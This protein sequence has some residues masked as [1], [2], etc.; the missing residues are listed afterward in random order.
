MLD[1]CLRTTRAGAFLG[2]IAS[3]AVNVG[4]FSAWYCPRFTYLLSIAA[5]IVFAIATATAAKS[6]IRLRE[7][8]RNEGQ[9]RIISRSSQRLIRRWEQCFIVLTA[10]Y[11][12]ICLL[13]PNA[14][15]GTFAF[16]EVL[17]PDSSRMSVDLVRRSGASL[18]MFS[19][20]LHCCGA[21]KK[22]RHVGTDLL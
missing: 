5:L 9:D 20:S 13:M 21:E 16:E 18:A 15:L 11:A 4:T 10:A 1:L 6:R 2:A 8:A 17:S 7:E 12:T 3:L 22:G 19:V 14:L